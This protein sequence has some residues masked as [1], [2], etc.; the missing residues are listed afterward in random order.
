[1][2][3]NLELYKTQVSDDAII[4]YF[5]YIF[6]QKLDANKSGF[7]HDVV[8]SS[9][10]I[11]DN[12][13]KHIEYAY[14][15]NDYK[16]YRYFINNLYKYIDFDDPIYRQYIKNK[17]EFIDKLDRRLYNYVSNMWCDST[18]YKQST[19]IIAEL[20]NLDS[21]NIVQKNG[22]HSGE[23]AHAIISISKYYSRRYRIDRLWFIKQMLINYVKKRGD[24]LIHMKKNIHDIFQF[25]ANPINGL[26]FN[27]PN[28]D[29][30]IY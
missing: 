5:N 9:K 29:I 15:N 2:N 22:K 16:L 8:A 24:D 18:V 20:I 13:K 17:V 28:Y 7:I 21:I 6:N 4:I 19:M 1:M 3:K 10:H 26:K 30:L 23:H 14:R 27:D 25:V 11:K 12:L